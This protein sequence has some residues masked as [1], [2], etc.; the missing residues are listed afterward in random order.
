M[1]GVEGHG[2][3]HPDEGPAQPFV[4]WPGGSQVDAAGRLARGVRGPEK[5]GRGPRTVPGDDHGGQRLEG[6]DEDD[7]LAG[8]G[9]TAP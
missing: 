5:D 7:R 6:A 9:E 8:E 2:A 3:Q 1:G 4:G